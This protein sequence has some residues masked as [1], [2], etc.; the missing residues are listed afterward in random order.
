MLELSNV[1]TQIRNNNNWKSESRIVGE[2]CE[3]YIKKN[4]KCVRCEN[5]NFEKCKTNEKSKDLI[6]LEC[7]QKYQIKAKC[8]TE[9]Q[10]EKIIHNKKFKTIG[11]EYSTT[12]NN[13]NQN[14]D[15]IIII[16]KKTSYEVIKMLYIKNEFINTECITPR[17][18]LSLTAKRS[19]W[20][21]CHIT[22]NNFEII[23]LG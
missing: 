12:I 2:A 17:K 14:I 15:Y 9:K 23:T 11:G 20:Q 8:G 4:M 22:F 6:C 16:Y 10:I 1:V 13:I 21:G 7:N 5:I 3:E 18:P 19:G